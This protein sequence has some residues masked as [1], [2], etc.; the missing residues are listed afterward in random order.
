MNTDKFPDLTD[1]I[2]SSIKNPKG[3]CYNKLREK[4]ARFGKPNLKATYLRLTMGNPQGSAPGHNY[5]IEVWPPGHYSPIHSHSS[6]YAVIRV[7]S[8]EILVRLYPAL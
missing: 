7:L 8:G 4:A 5:V 1:V 3:W 6:T 2:A